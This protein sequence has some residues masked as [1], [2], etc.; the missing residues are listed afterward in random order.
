MRRLV[1]FLAL[2]ASCPAHAQQ[3]TEEDGLIVI[4]EEI[5][6]DEKQRETIVAKAKELPPQKQAEVTQQVRLAESYRAQAEAELVKAKAEKNEAVRQ[7]HMREA[8]DKADLARRIQRRA[9][10]VVAPSIASEPSYVGAAPRG[11]IAPGGG[12]ALGQLR[13]SAELG[14]S[15]VGRAGFGES[16]GRSADATAYDPRRGTLV[17]SGG[18]TINVFPVI[19]RVQ[20]ATGGTVPPEKVF[21]PARQPDGSTAYRLSPAARNAVDTA[22]REEARGSDVGG[23][24][25]RVTLD[26]LAFAGLPDFRHRA[27]ARDI[28]RPV[29]LSLR[30]LAEAVGPLLR[31]PGDWLRLPDSLRYPGNIGRVYGFSRSS[32]GS[33][34]I[35]IGDAAKAPRHR[36]SLDLIAV[37]LDAVW[38]RNV[39]PAVSLDP[40]PDGGRG[41]QIARVEDIPRQS[42][43]ARILL[44]ADYAMKRITFGTL[45]LSIPGVADEIDETAVAVMR[46]GERYANRFWLQP[47]PLQP[48]AVRRSASGRTTLYAPAIT[49]RAEELLSEGYTPKDLAIIRN[50]TQRLA[51]AVTGALHTI[52]D[53]P[54]IQPQGIYGRLIGVNDLTVTAWL[55]RRLRIDAPS[56]SALATLPLPILSD[57]VPATYPEIVHEHASGLIVRG[58]ATMLS[59]ARS[60]ASD[61]YQDEVTARIERA[62]DDWSGGFAQ[63][64]PRSISVADPQLL[65][66]DSRDEA[67]RRADFLIA[68]GEYSSALALVDAQ[69][70]GDPFDETLLITRGHA[71]FE[72]GRIRDAMLTLQR[73]IALHGGIAELQRLV[74]RHLLD[75]DPSAD[76]SSFDPALRREASRFQAEVAK[77]L[78][79]RRRFELSRQALDRAL[80]LW[81]DNRDAMLLAA[82]G[83]DDPLEPGA[84]ALRAEAIARFRQDHRSAPNDE[85]AFILGWALAVDCSAWLRALAEDGAAPEEARR[86]AIAGLRRQVREAEAL[87]PDNPITK[88]VLLQVNMAELILDQQAGKPADPA[89]LLFL[90]SHFVPQFAD[91]SPMRVAEAQAALMVGRTDVAIDV[92]N[93]AVELDPENAQ[94][95]FLRAGI[96]SRMGQCGMAREDL[97]RAREL[98]GRDNAALSAQ[99]SLYCG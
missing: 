53:D 4:T 33:D 98:N 75:H 71:L 61:W 24:D 6:K 60:G 63:A 57:P 28:E 79:K 70:A 45:D 22:R 69:L 80:R 41:P 94:A 3:V 7:V 34:I 85:T 64:L 46:V 5:R 9:E 2:L 78:F 1:L 40:P 27:P 62:V 82:L 16:G 76:L 38:R 19:D 48:G 14:G 35:L 84:S 67:L 11:G 50:S 30:R 74:L 55:M 59:A 44:D 36:I 21:E 81:P 99:V 42:T 43:F 31:T 77:I 91:Y 18:Q 58:G 47:A 95:Y 87:L 8:L 52:S 88:V 37:A 90:L 32:D 68:S 10:E 66:G 92:V 56:L 20:R 89:S 17:T 49:I 73:A 23:V 93:R 97:R 12:T 86:K 15:D 65:G 96:A 39:V 51:E 72:L 54:R 83:R 25:L 26:L 29:L 13:R